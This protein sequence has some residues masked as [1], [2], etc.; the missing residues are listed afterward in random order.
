MASKSTLA[1]FKETRVNLDPTSPGTA[2]QILVPAHGQSQRSFRFA[3]QRHFP[4]NGDAAEDED[5]F[6]K[7]FL[8]SSGS[9]YFRKNKSYPRSFLWRVLEDRNILELRSIDL[10]KSE[11]DRHEATLILRLVFPNAIRT[12]GVA[13][14]DREDHDLLSVFVLTNRNELYTLTLRPDVFCRVAAT[15][16]NVQEWC[17]S[18]VPATFSISKPHRLLTIGPDELWVSLHDGRLLRLTRSV[19]S[20]GDSRIQPAG[21]KLT[22]VVVGSVWRETTYTDG[23]WGSSLRGLIR[24]QG[25]NT[26]RYEGQSLEQST[27]LS[28]AYSPDT[29]HLFT[30]CLNHTFKAWNLQTGVIDFTKDLLD[31]ERQPQELSQVLISP[32]GLQLIRTFNAERARGGDRYYVVT[33][34]PH[35]AGEFKF[36]AA[37]DAEDS[38]LAIQDLF[39]GLHLSPPDPDPSSGAIWTVADFEVKGSD[40]GFGMEL[41]V[42]LKQNHAYRVYTL[43]FDLLDLRSAW[44]SR[45]VTTTIETLHDVPE[46]RASNLD[47]SDAID[48]W[49]GFIFYPG[50]YTVP[51]LET[52]L[53]IYKQALRIKTTDSESR[54]KKSLRER[55]CTAIGSTVRLER[56]PE[57]GGDYERF[58]RDTNAQWSRFWMLA[59][60]IDK[61][62]WEAV[63]LSYDLFGGSSWV[64]TTDGCAVI[65]ECSDTEILAHN[66]RPDLYA[67]MDLIEAGL[68]DRMLGQQCDKHAGD[69][70]GLIHAATSFRKQFSQPLLHTCRVTLSTELW[71]DPSYSVPVRIQSFYDR[72]GFAGQIGDDEYN[73][74]VTS[75][76][77]IGGFQALDR[78]L[79]EAVIET[80]PLV[81]P[82][83]QSDLFST[84][85]GL[86]ILVKGAQETIELGA[87]ILFDLLMLVVFLEIEAYREGEL[88]E[89]FDAAKTYSDLIDLLQEY[90]MM[91]WLSRTSRPKPN[92]KREEAVVGPTSRSATSVSPGERRVSTVLEDLFAGDPRPLPASIHPQSAVIT[93]NIRQVVSW[94]TR[95]RGVP[96]DNA[97]VY[98]QCNL[99]VTENIGLAWG[100]L[101]YQPTTAWSTYV[102]GR[103]YLSRA[104]YSVAA[105]HFKKAAFVLG[106]IPSSQNGIHVLTDYSPRHGIR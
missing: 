91:R 79:F 16:G 68:Q 80:L 103:L 78:Y 32:S 46:P 24:W 82:K 7:R 83:D 42:L 48:A 17:K 19:G 40:E 89:D 50:K 22:P 96:L 27:A 102:K 30:V 76:E 4:G 65:R 28:M 31:K 38:R 52:S 44:E 53:S 21:R 1:L 94:I 6:S 18:F 43:T 86:K 36:W 11:H 98:I 26:I 59:R 54:S 15:E 14:S 23:A 25:N 71:R 77:R 67:Q 90:E 72:C 106:I 41:W 12:G 66:E 84:Q 100:F 81:F 60:D 37:R 51:V 47:P 101:C 95:A 62:R 56:L 85:F 105:L 45:W 57:G 73:N 2:I 8:A 104:E 39:P 64:V 70:A 58:R 88:M 10:T 87:Q 61:Q 35:D 29:L 55:I 69:V 13:L 74:L 20:D 63:S 33:F 93:Y 3:Q 5:A 49:L 99:L 97:L 75:L 34:S 9:L 92:K